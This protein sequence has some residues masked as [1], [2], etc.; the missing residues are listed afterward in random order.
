MLQTNPIE[1]QAYFRK[2][3]R[4]S[5]KKINTLVKSRGKTVQGEHSQERHPF[6]CTTI[7]HST[8]P[9][10]QITLTIISALPRAG[11]RLNTERQRASERETGSG[12]E[13]EERE[14]DS[15]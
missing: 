7:Q 15:A 9:N 11:S 10:Q 8:T 14:G 5:E 2:G 4:E 12:K 3:R 6:I 1:E 13:R